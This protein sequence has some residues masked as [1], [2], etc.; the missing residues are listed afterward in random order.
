MRALSGAA[1]RLGLAGAAEEAAAPSAEEDRQSIDAVI[2]RYFGN[3]KMIE[4]IAEAY[5]INV[6]FVWQQRACEHVFAR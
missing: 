3:K 5:G 1:R 6:A 2:Q 4:A